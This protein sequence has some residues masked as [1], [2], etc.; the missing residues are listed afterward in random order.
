MTEQ[1]D[2]LYCLNAQGKEQ[3]I[4]LTL[5]PFLEFRSRTLILPPYPSSRAWILLT[6]RSDST[7]ETVQL[8]EGDMVCFGRERFRY[9]R[10]QEQR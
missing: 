1:Y 2:G 5:V 8:Q 9:E 6:D 10:V 3:R 4:V 7:T